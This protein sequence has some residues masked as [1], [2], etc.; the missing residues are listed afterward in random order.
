MS[1]WEFW[2]L[3]LN[4]NLKPD[5]VLENEKIVNALKKNISF[6]IV[7]LLVDNEFIN[8]GI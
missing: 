3:C 1:E 7:A 5:I 2:T 6:D 4:K 8:K